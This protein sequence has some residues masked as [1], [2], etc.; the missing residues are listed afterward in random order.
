MKSPQTKLSKYATVNDLGDMR[1]W[2]GS[3]NG[4]YVCLIRYDS[5]ID[6]VQQGCYYRG[7]GNPSAEKLEQ[8]RDAARTCLKN[9]QYG[10]LQ[11]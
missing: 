5:I 2:F 7:E 3:D 6:G 10:E 11:V 9:K 4:D 1:E 8:I